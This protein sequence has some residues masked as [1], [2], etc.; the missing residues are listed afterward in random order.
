MGILEFVWKP[1]TRYGCE[2][3]EMKDSQGTLMQRESKL[4]QEKKLQFTF[5]LIPE[6]SA[7]VVPFVEK[8][9]KAL[10]VDLDPALRNRSVVLHK[11]GNKGEI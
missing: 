10:A 11:R 8:E 2:I 9:I 7:R 6:D 4:L 5:I 1:F 3:V